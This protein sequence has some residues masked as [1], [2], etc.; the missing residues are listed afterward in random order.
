MPNM[1]HLTNFC[2]LALEICTHMSNACTHEKKSPELADTT[3][4]FL[5]HESKQIL[6][7][8]PI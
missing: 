8:L 7:Y 2:C 6:K 4:H 1:S 3:Y 5:I